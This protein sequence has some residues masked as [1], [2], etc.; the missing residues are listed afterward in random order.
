M[1]T[2]IATTAGLLLAGSALASGSLDNHDNYGS[3]LLDL[4]EDTVT[5]KQPGFGGETGMQRSGS[6]GMGDVPA[7][8]HGEA[9]NYSGNYGSILIGR[10]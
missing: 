3:V 9:L 4:S 6:S 8:L 10:R 1:K 7:S 5:A 2:L